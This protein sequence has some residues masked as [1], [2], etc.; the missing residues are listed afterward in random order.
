MVQANLLDQVHGGSEPGTA[1]SHPA[2]NKIRGF[3]APVGDDDP[4]LELISSHPEAD[5][6]IQSVDDSVKMWLRKIGRIPLLTA[7]QEIALARGAQTG[8]TKC[9]Q[10][11]LDQHLL[12]FSGAGLSAPR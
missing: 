5:A 8:S 4:E 11:G 2:I 9:K 12:T 10:I 3:D 7:E 1:H 6:D